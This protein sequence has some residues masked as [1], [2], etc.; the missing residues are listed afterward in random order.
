M[1]IRHDYDDVGKV[2]SPESANTW[3][4]IRT[5]WRWAI[6]TRTLPSC[7]GKILWLQA[8]K[9]PVESELT[10]FIQSRSSLDTGLLQGKVL[11]WSR[12]SGCARSLTQESAGLGQA[13]QHCYLG[14]A[15]SPSHRFS[16]KNLDLLSR[17]S[18]TPLRCPCSTVGAWFWH[19][20]AWS[21]LFSTL[22]LRLWAESSL[23]F[24]EVGVTYTF[25]FTVTCS[26]PHLTKCLVSFTIVLERK[27]LLK[28]F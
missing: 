25:I 19:L 22:V 27:V 16:T 17:F 24:E 23:C 15:T 18:Q 2:C 11:P 10:S 4:E 12:T 3:W 13:L 28:L 7:A 21:C 5:N 14:G 1:D 8:L 6:N 9:Y 26:G 20:P